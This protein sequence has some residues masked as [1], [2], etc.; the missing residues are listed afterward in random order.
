MNNIVNHA[1]EKKKI[2][3][4]VVDLLTKAKELVQQVPDLMEKRTEFVKEPTLDELKQGL[5]VNFSNIASE[6]KYDLINEYMLMEGFDKINQGVESMIL[7]L[8]L[9]DKNSEIDNFLKDAGK[10]LDELF[11][12]TILEMLSSKLDSL[13]SWVY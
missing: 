5:K 1:E 3:V 13:E 6:V 2:E 11:K 8:T 7:A 4:Q 10:N 9:E 12:F